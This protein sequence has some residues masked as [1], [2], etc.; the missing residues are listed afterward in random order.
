MLDFASDEKQQIERVNQVLLQL[1][2]LCSDI[3][4]HY[5][6]GLWMLI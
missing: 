1:I 4:P 6:I 2:A 3:D 5:L